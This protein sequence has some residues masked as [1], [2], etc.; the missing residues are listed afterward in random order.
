ME[1]EI[2]RKEQQMETTSMSEFFTT[3]NRRTNENKY[4]KLL[5][6]MRSLCVDASHRGVFQTKLILDEN[7]FQQYLDVKVADINH[8]R[9][10]LVAIF[11]ELNNF[12]HFA[13]DAYKIHT[14]VILHDS[15]LHTDPSYCQLVFDWHT[16]GHSN[17]LR[18]N[19]PFGIRYCDP[20]IS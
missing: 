12:V 15:V 16:Q 9:A 2:I 13:K 14:K 11:N 7:N 5:Q 17:E 6:R 18:T 20:Q 1:M 8:P 10:L 4:H 3:L 19:E